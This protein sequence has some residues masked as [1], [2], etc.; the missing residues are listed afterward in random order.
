MDAATPYGVA[1]S[2]SGPLLTAWL[3]PFYTM[4]RIH[5][6]VPTPYRRLVHRSHL[7]VS[8]QFGPDLGSGE[9]GGHLAPRA[10]Y[11][12]QSSKKWNTHGKQTPCCYGSC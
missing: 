10:N 3:R 7:G 12:R 1:T 6:G 9:S 4:V 2:V 11:S 5:H 8:T